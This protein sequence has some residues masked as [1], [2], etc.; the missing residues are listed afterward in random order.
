MKSIICLTLMLAVTA[1]SKPFEI[2]VRQLTT[3]PATHFFGYIGHVGN[4]PWSGDGRYILAMRTAMLDHLPGADDPAEIILID[5][6]RGDA[7]TVVDETRAWNPQQGTM[8]Y[9]NPHASDTQFFFNDR[10]RETGRVFTVLYDIVKR[11]RIREYRVEGTAVANS[12][13]AQKGGHFYAINYARMARLRKVTGY[14]GATDTT[15][16]VAH[17]KNDGVFKIGIENGKKTLLVSFHQL[18]EAL[19][20]TEKYTNV[21]ALF[22]NHTL[23]NRENDRVFFFAR[24]GWDGHEGPK[25][26][27]GFVMRPDGSEL[28]A[29]KDH[30]GGHPEWD[31]GHRMIGRIDEKQAIYDIDRQEM[32][33][34]LGNPDIFPNPE[35]DVALSPDGEWFVNGFKNRK[36]KST[37]YVVYR[38]SDGASVRSPGVNIG[39]LASGDLRQDPSPCWNRSNNQILVPA[40]A[41]DG[42]SR[43]LFVLTIDS[44]PD[45]R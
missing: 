36:A 16:G 20:A 18:A 38:R 45:S 37:Y 21:P 43:Q 31:A 4:V 17:P 42:K 32:V 28:M 41:E 7:I 24:G 9:W 22:I 14:A 25:V 8:F 6:Q 40:I 35:G 30:I 27:Q 26:N 5:T 34:Q 3:G 39:N 19:R 15:E 1:S 23:A 13:V 11:E 29:I 2:K 44:E 10:D 12:G 33:G